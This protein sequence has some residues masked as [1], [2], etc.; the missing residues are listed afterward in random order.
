VFASGKPVTV[1]RSVFSKK[2][3]AMWE[4]AAN[5]CVP[6]KKL[7]SVL[8]RLQL[9]TVALVNENSGLCGSREFLL[10]LESRG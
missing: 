9:V 1:Q 3:A 6:S 7:S 2:H 8:V 10:L 4:V 5:C